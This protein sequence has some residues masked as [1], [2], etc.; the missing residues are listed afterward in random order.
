MEMSLSQRI[1]RL[2]EIIN[3]FL[4]VPTT[5][6]EIITLIW[7]FIALMNTKFQVSNL[8]LDVVFAIMAIYPFGTLLLYGYRK[9]SRGQT[10][11]T[12]AFWLWVG[13]IGFNLAPLFWMLS[14]WANNNFTI[15]DKT[16]ESWF[17]NILG[18]YML[19]ILLAITALINDLRREFD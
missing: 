8:H 3:Y 7:S 12:S 17:Y 2:L 16:S 14:I 19:V 18:Y 15:R 4:L 11:K 13:T 5:L 1:A 6:I 9:H 10:S